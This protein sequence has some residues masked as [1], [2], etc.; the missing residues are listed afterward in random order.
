M[1]FAALSLLL[2]GL[3]PPV[4]GEIGSHPLYTFHGYVYLDGR[5]IDGAS[6]TFRNIK[7][8]YIEHYV[9]SD[10][11]YYQFS[12]GAD[13]FKPSPIREGDFIN[14][15]AEYG[16]YIGYAQFQIVDGDF[17][18]P[19]YGL[20]NITLKP[21][22]NVAEPEDPSSGQRVIDFI[23]ESPFL[24][25]YIVIIAVI[26]SFAALWYK[27]KLPEVGRAQSK[28]KGEERKGKGS[29]RRRK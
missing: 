14:I 17:V 4:G 6:V 12:M 8:D 27:G 2:A 11:G 1:L 5:Q 3:C 9:T 16:D 10:G 18:H 21:N 15:T 23:S 13:P 19:E 20:V 29:S 7:T 22:P 28:K 24:V 25:A 26:I